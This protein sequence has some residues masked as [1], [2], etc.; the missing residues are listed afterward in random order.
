MGLIHC[1]DVHGPEA[2]DDQVVEWKRGPRSEVQ[3]WAN[4]REIALIAELGGPLRDPLARCKQTLNLTKGG[5]WGCNFEAI[6]ALRT[7]AWLKFKSEMQEYAECYETSLV[8]RDYVNR[9]SGY[10]LGQRL[11]GVRQGE[12][13]RGHPDEANRVEWLESLPGWAWKPRESDE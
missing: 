11:S 7:I 2:F 5:K 10:K 6:D 4:E 9:V 12:L 8:S 1:L 3:A 13:W